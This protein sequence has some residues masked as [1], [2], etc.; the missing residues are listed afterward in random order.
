M[1]A[2]P[3]ELPL[4]ELRQVLA[5]LQSG[6]IGGQKAEF[7]KNLWWVQGYAQKTFLGDG[8]IAKSAAPAEVTDAGAVEAVQKLIEQ[9]ESGA[10]A[11]GLSP[12]W[13]YL[14]AYA[15][16]KLLQYLKA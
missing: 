13:V 8:A 3:T 10:T 4:Y 9:A 7:A 1:A 16:E 2:Y 6:D 14:L 12:F 5:I 11:Q 15:A